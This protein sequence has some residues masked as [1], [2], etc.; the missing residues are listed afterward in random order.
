MPPA[1]HWIV[2][3]NFTETGGVAWRRAD[4]T[5]SH[6]IA[7]AGL[8]AD[9]ATAKQLAAASLATEQREISDPY[10]IEVH[11]EGTTID[12]LTARQRIRANGP[13]IPLR[14]PDSGL[15]RTGS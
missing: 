7:D 13:T 8:L 6:H 11:A 2:T 12:P 10:G 3:G 9:E 1:N 5:W 15:P 4:G 14:R